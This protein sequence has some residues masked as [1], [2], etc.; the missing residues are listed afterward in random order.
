MKEV[1]SEGEEIGLEEVRRAI[2]KLK[3]GKAGGVCGI[4][5]EMVKAGGFTMIRWLKEVFDVAW[6]SGRTPQ[7]WREAIIIP[8]HKKGCKAECGNYRGISLL[9]VVGKVYARILSDRLR[10]E[11]NGVVMDKQGGFRPGRGCV[12]D[13][14]FNVRQ[15]I[16]KVIEKDRVAFAAFVDLEKAYD[17]VS[18]DK[19]WLALKEHNVSKQLLSAMQSLYE[20]GWARVRVGERE[21]PQVQVRKGVRQGC[22][23]S[24]WLF[25][26][27]IDKI[28]SEARKRFQGSV[29]LST[30]QVEVLL[31]ADDLV[32]LAESEEAL[33]NNLQVVNDE[34]E[35]WGMR[36]NWLKTKVMR[37]ARKPEECRIEVNSER[38]EQIEEMKYLGA[39]ISGNGSMD[40]E[41]ELRIGMA[42]RM[43]GAIG[44]SVLGRKELTKGTKLRVVNAM[45]LPTLTYGCETWTLQTRHRGR[46]E[47]MQMR[48]MRRIEG[49]TRLD[50]IRN[51]DL[52]DRLKQEGVLD[53][54]KRR[55]QRWK[56]RL[57]EMDD[58]RIKK[59]VYDG[60]I[61]GRRPRGRPRK[62]WT[63]NFD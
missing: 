15:V 60:E 31:F 43:I 27:F 2:K 17:S 28:V 49:V 45:V 63:N 56:Q 48:V 22:P 50:S 32:V 26:V 58:S 5:A 4:Q 62:R 12:V 23:L 42:A 25:N 39:M 55:Q 35:V 34:L 59:R 21:S 46:V 7:E 8:I 3:N 1:H 38:V 36:A 52:R 61:A 16:E 19:L 44:S 30:G 9:S 47:A 41:V 37:I 6:R 20:N 11:T 14:I 18:R 29:R 40:G 54:V 10:E 51:V 24:P 33:Q 53:L 13:Q 57:E